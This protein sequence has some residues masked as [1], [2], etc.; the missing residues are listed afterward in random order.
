VLSDELLRRLGLL[1][2]CGP[3]V[4]T[5]NWPKLLD[6]LRVTSDARVLALVGA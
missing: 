1:H 4:S 5:T 6:G 3:G 2:A